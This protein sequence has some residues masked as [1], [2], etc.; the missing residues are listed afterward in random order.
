MSKTAVNLAHLLEESVHRWEPTA[1]RDWSVDARGSITLDAD[2]LRLGVALDALIENAVA[3]THDG[4][5]IALLR[6]PP[7]RTLPSR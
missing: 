2:P 4:A 6:S 3:H 7:D 5:R 1:G